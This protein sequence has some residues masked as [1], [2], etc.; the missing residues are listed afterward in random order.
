M[1]K[2]PNIPGYE[3]NSIFYMKLRVSL[4]ETEFLRWYQCMSPRK[5]AYIFIPTIYKGGEFDE[6]IQIRY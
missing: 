2:L 3:K 6:S 5:I 1:K 4:I